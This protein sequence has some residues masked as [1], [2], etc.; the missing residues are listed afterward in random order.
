MNDTNGINSMPPNTY[1]LSGEWGRANSDQRHRFDLLGSFKPGPWFT[2]GVVLSVRS[3]RPYSLVLGRDIYNTGNANARPP[4]V[5]RNS[6][7]GPDYTELDLKWSH[8]VPLRK[9]D[10]EGPKL[11]LGVEAFNVL[12]RV[13]YA[14]YIGNLS[15]PFF[16]QAVAAQPPRRFQLSVTFEM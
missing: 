15:S 16:G 11:T 4:G 2:L 12:N 6:L 5:G 8:E 14:G 13:N 10:D 3:G 7:V 9:G 1:D